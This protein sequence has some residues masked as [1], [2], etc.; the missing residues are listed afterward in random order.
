WACGRRSL[1]VDTRGNV[2]SGGGALVVEAVDKR[3]ADRLYPRLESD[4]GARVT[5]AESGHS[6]LGQHSAIVV[7]TPIFGFHEPAGR[8][9]AENV[10]TV[11]NASAHEPAVTTE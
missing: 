6:R 10:Q 11:L 1:G 3:R 8:G 7:G 4:H 5:T 9:H 2:G